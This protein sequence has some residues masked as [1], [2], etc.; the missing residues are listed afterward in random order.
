MAG[1]FLIFSG[2]IFSI[3]QG[4][5]RI[6]FYLNLI[7]ILLTLLMFWHHATDTLKIIL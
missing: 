4:Q 2:A 3:W 1:L 7:G 5:H 6:A